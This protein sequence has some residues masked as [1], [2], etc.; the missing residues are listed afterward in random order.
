MIKHETV[1]IKT[2]IQIPCAFGSQLEPFCKE[3][4]ILF[5]FKKGYKAFDYSCFWNNEI[6]MFCWE[7]QV[8]PLNQEDLF[9]TY[10]DLYEIVKEFAAHKRQQVFK[11][12]D[13][14]SELKVRVLTHFGISSEPYV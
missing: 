10:E 13:L 9:P 12:L 14:S 11:G 1:Y 5:L 7:C 4:V 3:D 2:D 8:R 6:D